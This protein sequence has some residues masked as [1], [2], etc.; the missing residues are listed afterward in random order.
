MVIVGRVNTGKSTL[1][2]RIIR[3][4]LAVTD[5]RPGVTRD[6]VAKPGQWNGVGFI[7]VD[8]GGFVAGDDPLWPQVKERISVSVQDADVV[9]LVLDSKDG[10]T[11]LD[12]EMADWLRKISKSVLVVANKVD[13]SKAAPQEFYSLGFERVF[14]VSGITGYGLEELMESVIELLPVKSQPIA[15]KTPLIRTSILGKPNV[16]KSSLLNALTGGT[17][18]ITSP[19]PGTTRDP[20]EAVVRKK[21]LVLD[22][23]GIRRVFKDDIEYYSHLRSIRSLRYAE[24][25]IV[26]LDA[27]Q[28]IHR[29]DKK[30]I[31]TVIEEGRG[32]VIAVNKT[33]TVPQRHRSKLFQAFKNQ[34]RFVSWAPLLMVSALKEWGLDELVA[35]VQTVH[36]EFH[37][38][39]GSDK[40]YEMLQDAVEMVSPGVM[41][42][43]MKQVR[44]GPPVFRLR[45][46]GKLRPDYLSFL[47]REIRARWGFMGVPIKIEL[48]VP[49]SR[50]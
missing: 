19:V 3:K 47:Q 39:V 6:A 22:T 13:S 26:V 15:S 14:Q 4:G 44:K 35:T 7:L 49:R 33:D 41:L 36:R 24:V 32:L 45:A 5:S 20:V 48:S 1:F 8:T 27:S 37:K 34:L 50:K 11:P 43:G 17:A 18:A 23:A 42:T 29:I 46:L 10:L 28:G 40:L 25:C 9:L 21:L 16:G 2:N 30:I 38:Q 31:N 12:R